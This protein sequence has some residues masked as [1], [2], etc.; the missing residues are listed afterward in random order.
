M[1]DLLKD[2]KT[3]YFV[4]SLLVLLII[5]Y[6]AWG[7]GKGSKSEKMLN[8]DSSIRRLGGNAGG[9]VTNLWETTQPGQGPMHNIHRPG[10]AAYW[11][12]TDLPRSERFTDQ[13][14]LDYAQFKTPGGDKIGSFMN[15]NIDKISNDE[16]DRLRSRNF[17]NYKKCLE[18]TNGSVDQCSIPAPE[19]I[20]AQLQS[21]LNQANRRNF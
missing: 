12:G 21:V 9:A 10:Y 16:R 14:L 15:S 7:A 4:V 17:E 11:T 18:L 5:L 6:I 20:N 19:Y 8:I 3:T 13:N 2:I 1:F